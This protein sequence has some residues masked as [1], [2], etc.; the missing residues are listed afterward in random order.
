MLSDNRQK[1]IWKL[2]NVVVSANT[3]S[4]EKSDN[5]DNADNN[6]DASADK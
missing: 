1:L 4:N 3:N 6:V 2:I 5:N